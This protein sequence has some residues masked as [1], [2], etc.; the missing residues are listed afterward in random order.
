VN[1]KKNENIVFMPF[2]GVSSLLILVIN[3]SWCPLQRI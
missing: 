2:H 1:E 3:R